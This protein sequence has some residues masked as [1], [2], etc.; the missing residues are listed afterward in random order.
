MRRV[1]TV[2]RVNKNNPARFDPTRT[3]MLRTAFAAELTRRLKALAREIYKLV[4]EE[5]AFGLS[6]PVANVGRWQFATNDQKLDEFNR[7]LQ[8]QID[9]K[10][11]ALRGGSDIFSAKY[12]DSA[13][14]KGLVNAFIAVKKKDMIKDPDYYKKSQA[15]FL[16]T[17]FA[18]PETVSKVKLLATRSYEDLKGMTNTMATQMSRTLADGLIHGRGAMAIAR[19]LSKRVD[20]SIGRART[21]ARTEIIFA[22]AQGQLDAFTE[23]GVEE[24]GVMAEWST[25]GDD[26][27]C[28]QC[29]ELEGVVM[30]VEEAQGLIPRHPN[31]RCTWIPANVNE[32]AKGQIKT[33]RGIEA[34]ISRSAKAETGE[35]TAAAARDASRWQGVDIEVSTDRDPAG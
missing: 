20:I 16:T 24:V 30:T 15:E 9:S 34:A 13:Y 35:S 23:L 27:V 21:I 2:R 18:A 5:D 4:V 14:R 1:P 31:C 8:T 19:D 12:V 28:P 11:I 26:R 33:A 6:Q 7:W 17:A 10:V 29:E 22:H 25:A 32:K 3:T